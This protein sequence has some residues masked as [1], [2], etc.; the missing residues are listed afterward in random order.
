MPGGELH[1]VV[2]VGGVS[3][4]AVQVSWTLTLRYTIECARPILLYNVMH[5]TKAFIFMQR[6]HYG[7]LVCRILWLFLMVGLLNTG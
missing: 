2:V 3:W 4:P 6:I 5:N 1:V 7:Y